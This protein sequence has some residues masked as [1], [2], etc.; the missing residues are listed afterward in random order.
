MEQDR[1]NQI[2]D[3]L[4][5]VLGEK[6]AMR[7]IY[8]VNEQ[9]PREVKLLAEQWGW[10]DTEVR[11]KT[12]GWIKENIDNIKEYLKKEDKEFHTN[13]DQYLKDRGW[14]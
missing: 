5:D 10:H 13:V 9:L 12:Y 2:H 11:E 6:P 14:K 3:R 1:F 4:F 7:D 8:F